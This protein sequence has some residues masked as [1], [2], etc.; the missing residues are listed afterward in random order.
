MAAVL[1]CGAVVFYDTG[2]ITHNREVAPGGSLADSGWQYQG[3]FGVYLGTMIS[4]N[5]FITASHIGVPSTN[6]VSPSY[7]NGVSDVTY[8]INTSVNAGTGYWQLPGTDLR[9]FEILE[10]FPSYA[11]LYEGNDEVGKDLVVMGRGTQRGGTVDLSSV[12]KG[13][14]PGASDNK[15]RWGTNTV[16]GIAT[17]SG[18]E[19][20]VA[21]FDAM[22]GTDEAHLTSG[23]SGGAVFIKDAGVWKLAGIN[24]AVE[25]DWD[26]NGL[27]DGNGFGAS[28][29][30]SGGLYVGSDSAGWNFITDTVA[31]IPSSFY[32]SRISNYIAPI[33]TITGVPEPEVTVLLLLGVSFFM[34]R[35]R[36]K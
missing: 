32:S 21:D 30:D 17:L 19:Y 7:F 26:F 34:R 10:T 36:K 27:K 13:W 4:P 20:L 31:D 35:G 3:E 14:R 33:N 18:A 29:F 11:A 24:F 9:I 1:P 2:D 5:H 12:L 22:P 23:D 16:S 6:F 8:N 15:A 25:G 28:L